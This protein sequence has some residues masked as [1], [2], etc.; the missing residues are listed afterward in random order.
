MLPPVVVDW[1][2]KLFPCPRA[3]STRNCNLPIDKSIMRK[4]NGIMRKVPESGAKKGGLSLL[5]RLLL[6]LLALTAGLGATLG[7][8]VLVVDSESLVDLGT[9]S[10]VILET[11]SWVSYTLV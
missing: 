9:Q 2:Q 10:G 7:L 6:L 11:V 4:R 5:L 3:R 8:E 1:Y